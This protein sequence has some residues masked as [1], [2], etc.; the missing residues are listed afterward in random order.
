MM[1]KVLAFVS[2]ALI[3]L[4]SF[5][6]CDKQTE[7]PN[8]VVGT[9]DTI[10]YSAS[11]TPAVIFHADTT[12]HN[13]Q[14]TII[15]SKTSIYTPGTT[16][17]PSI[18]L[19]LPNAEGYYA[20]PGSANATVVTSASGAGGSAAISGWIQVVQK[21]TTGRFEGKFAFTTADGTTVT[22]GQFDGTLSYY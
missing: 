11:G 4:Y 3:C 17:Q 15:T 7:Y 19:K 22:S 14:M 2:L 18:T 16:T 13:P 5:T 12:T 9:I 8:S 21:S 1:K 6:G 20:I 10:A